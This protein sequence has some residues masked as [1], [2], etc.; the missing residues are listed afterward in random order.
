MKTNWLSQ[1]FDPNQGNLQTFFLNQVKEAKYFVPKMES[2]EVNFSIVQQMP[3][4]VREALVAI[5]FSD[6]NK[7]LQALSQLDATHAEKSLNQKTI[8]NNTSSSLRHHNSQNHDNR[9][10][11]KVFTS[12]IRADMCGICCCARSDSGK[13]RVDRADSDRTGKHVKSQSY[14]LTLDL[15]SFDLPNLSIPPPNIS[16]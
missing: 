8:R 4:R 5:D 12:R 6:M 14:S 9:D 1:R 15:Q 2:Y 11:N 13:N 16:S 10:R 3:I 7:G